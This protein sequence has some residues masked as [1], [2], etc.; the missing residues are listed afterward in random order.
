LR[1]VLGRIESRFDGDETESSR[2]DG[3]EIES[4]RDETG[5]LWRATL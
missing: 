1:A 5:S 4:S 2:F 3:D